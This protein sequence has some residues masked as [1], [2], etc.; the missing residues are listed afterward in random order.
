MDFRLPTAEETQVRITID[1]DKEPIVM[2]LMDLDDLHSDADALGK[3]MEMTTTESFIALFQERF[4][5]S[6]TKTQVYLLL[7][8]KAKQFTELKKNCL[9]SDTSSSSM[10]TLQD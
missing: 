4:G 9:L 5:H 7:N 10:D 6:L 8:Y 2:D 1:K 3:K